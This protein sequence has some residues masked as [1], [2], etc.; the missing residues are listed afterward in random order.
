MVQIGWTLAKGWDAPE[1]VPFQNFSISPSCCALQ[2]GFECFEG[3]KAF[4]DECGQLRMFRPKKNFERLNKSAKRIALPTFDVDSLV[5]ILG[6]FLKLED[7]WIP[8]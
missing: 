1:I 6:Q 7:R 5:Q 3:M 4:K 2:Y 8:A